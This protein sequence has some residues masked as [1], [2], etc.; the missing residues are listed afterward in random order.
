VT[1]IAVDKHSISWDSQ[2]TKGNERV[3]SPARKV[4]VIDGVIFALAGDYGRFDDLIQWWKAG[5]V[6][7]KAPGGHWNFIVIQSP[8]HMLFYM[9]SDLPGLR[10]KPPF[11]MGSGEQFALGRLDA[12][13]AT[14][15]DAVKSATQ[16]D[17]Y[18]GGSVKTLRFDRVWPPVKKRS[19]AKLK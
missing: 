1:T 17:V 14:A 12:P 13:G 19:R 9:S 15:R 4:R 7:K 5:A 3:G 10:F 11:A 18:T 2:I 6:E 16:H 8:T